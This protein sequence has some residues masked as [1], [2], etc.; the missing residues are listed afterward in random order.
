MKKVF[1][2]LLALTSLLLACNKELPP[3]DP[4]TP[5]VTLELQFERV[6]LSNAQYAMTMS[7]GSTAKF[8]VLNNNGDFVDAECS[9]TEFYA[10]GSTKPKS[11]VIVVPGAVYDYEDGKY[12]L[13]YECRFIDAEGRELYHKGYSKAEVAP[14]FI[15]RTDDGSVYDATDFIGSL[16]SIVADN[17]HFKTDSKGDVYVASES[18]IYRLKFRDRKVEYTVLLNRS[19]EDVAMFVTDVDGVFISSGGG[20]SFSDGV[21]WAQTLYLNNPSGTELIDLDKY[22]VPNA[23]NQSILL[24]HVGNQLKLY[25]NVIIANG[26]VSQATISIADVDYD[27]SSLIVSDF[28]DYKY[29]TTAPFEELGVVIDCDDYYVLE[30]SYDGQVLVCSKTDNSVIKLTKGIDWRY[31]GV[32]KLVG[33]SRIYLDYSTRIVRKFDFK[34]LEY[35]EIPVAE[36]RIFDNYAEFNQPVVSDKAGTLAIMGWR[37]MGDGSR[38]IFEINASSGNV[39]VF[40]I[41]DGHIVLEFAKVN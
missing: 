40:D 39:K 38:I 8:V 18:E 10:D 7:T 25:R 41:P 2:S 22:M 17:Y 36:T 37:V 28:T 3:V 35:Q 20:N 27:G 4:A 5:I 32:S 1:F 16:S 23:S 14:T 13:L 33:T 24:F 15:V 12:L 19:Y 6:D 31:L 30:S 26:D 21:L 34:T 9:F 29:T 11:G